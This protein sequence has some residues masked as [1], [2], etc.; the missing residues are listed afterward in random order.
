MKLFVINTADCDFNSIKVRLKLRRL[1]W[2]VPQIVLFQFHKGT[3][4]TNVI[5]FRYYLSILF[6]FHKGTIK[7]HGRQDSLYIN[8]ISIP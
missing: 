2:Q 8:L 3:I 5:I 4:K 7:T 1:A 6:Q